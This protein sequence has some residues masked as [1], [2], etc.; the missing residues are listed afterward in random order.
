MTEE[1]GTPLMQRVIDGGLDRGN[2][3][4]ECLRRN[5]YEA[6]QQND[7]DVINSKTQGFLALFAGGYRLLTCFRNLA[8]R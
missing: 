7:I 8:D 5:A 4:K 2:L 3:R 1:E 6:M